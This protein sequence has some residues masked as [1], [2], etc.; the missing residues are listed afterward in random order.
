MKIKIVFIY[1]VTAFFLAAHLNGQQSIFN[2]LENIE[3]IREEENEILNDWQN[4]YFSKEDCGCVYADEFFI[5]IKSSNPGS[6]NLMI[7][8]QG[9]GACWPGF[10]QCKP[11]VTDEDVQV[12]NFARELAERLKSDWNQVVIPYCDGSIYLGDN[13]NDYNNDGTI[14]HIHRGLNNSLAALN[15][16]KNKFPEVNRLFVTGCSAGGYGTIIQSRILKY[17]YPDASICIL[18]ESGPGLLNPDPEFWKM[19]DS[20]YNLSQ[21]MPENCSDCEVQ[22]IYWY[23]E[24]LKDPK[25]KIG[26]YSS[27][28]DQVIGQAFLNLPPEDYKE[29]LLKT[30][31]DLAS[32]YPGQFKR[33]F[34]NGN[35]HC[36][37]DR[38]IEVNDIKYWDWILSLINDDANWKDVLE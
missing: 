19:I 3:P 33:Y 6:K 15:L 32:R 20:S 23:E 16:V 5:S 21:L 22:L 35:T 13:K 7:S 30:S 1:T 11:S 38:N 10:I 36:I 9:G 27:Y 24:V 18:N 8:L 34:V 14:D 2:R 12:S 26:L 4:F 31:G 28:E 29:L 25:V 17:L 37:E